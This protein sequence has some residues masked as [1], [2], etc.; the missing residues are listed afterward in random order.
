[1]FAITNAIWLF[2]KLQE[3][4]IYPI[5]FHLQS[6]TLSMLCS[7]PLVFT[8]SSIFCGKANR[9]PLNFNLLSLASCYDLYS[10]YTV[11]QMKVFCDF[12]SDTV[13]LAAFLLLHLLLMLLHKISK[14]KKI[15]PFDNIHKAKN[16]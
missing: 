8:P 11:I 10:I 14:R 16:V 4:Q 12:T 6:K 13:S 7:G 2:K 9:P 5:S 15:A 3:K 1:M